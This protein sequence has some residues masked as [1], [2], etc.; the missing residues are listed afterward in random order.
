[1]D[2]DA[3]TGYEYQSVAGAAQ[4]SDLLLTGGMQGTFRAS[5][6]ALPQ[7]SSTSVSM[8]LNA[9][10]GGFGTNIDAVHPGARLSSLSY[11]LEAI[12]LAGQGWYDS[13]PDLVSMFHYFPVGDVPPADVQWNFQYADPFPSTWERFNLI[14]V[15]YDVR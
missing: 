1:T 8:L 6:P 11:Y 3:G 9:T 10:S 7:S 13:T 5:L 4:S 12:P 14:Y 2:L 15:S